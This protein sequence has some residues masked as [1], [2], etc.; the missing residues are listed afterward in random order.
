[1]TQRLTPTPSNRDQ[2]TPFTLE[3]PSMVEVVWGVPSDEM[4]HSE[5]A[6]DIVLVHDLNRRFPRRPL[7]QP[8]S[9]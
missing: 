2:H 7:E 6:G 4:F 1:M 9:L 5:Q 8:D 3:G